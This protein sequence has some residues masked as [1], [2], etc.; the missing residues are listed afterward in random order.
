MRNPEITGARHAFVNL[1][2][3]Q[4]VRTLKAL[5]GEA[6]F[7]QVPAFALFDI[8]RDDPHTACGVDSLRGYTLT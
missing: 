8:P 2:E 3:A 5:M 4:D 1:V 6:L 7:Q